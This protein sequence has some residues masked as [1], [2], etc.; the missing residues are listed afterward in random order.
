MRKKSG[1]SY[2]Y[3]D[4]ARS[5]CWIDKFLTVEENEVPIDAR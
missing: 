3:K 1:I 2:K 4:E 5:S